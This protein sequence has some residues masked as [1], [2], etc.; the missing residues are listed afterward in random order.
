M[1]ND[2]NPDMM[3]RRAGAKQ[4][5]S[6]I[7]R[8]AYEANVAEFVELN[9]KVSKDDKDDMR[10]Q[11]EEGY[12]HMSKSQQKAALEIYRKITDAC[13]IVQA[14]SKVNRK[15]RK[16]RIKSPEDVV[17]KLKFKQSDAEYGLGS[18]TPA[19]IIYA[20]VLVV[21]NTRNRKIG[22]YYASNVDP[23]GLQRDGSGLSVK[24]TTITGYDEEKSLQRT[25]RKPAEVLPELKKSTRAK[26]EKLIQSLK[27]TETKLN[28]RINGET[29][30]I[31]A[32]NK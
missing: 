11:L 5:H 30:L 2:F 16:L 6:R 25:I 32:F 21:F 13:D 14:E 12:E 9:T 15:P 23:M 10:E 1:V 29:I 4:A 26:T 19:D 31:A 28:G 3:L 17:K 20:R 7:I 22:T 8:K 18:I 27:T 24:G